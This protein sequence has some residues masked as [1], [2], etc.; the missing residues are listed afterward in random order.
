MSDPL[1]VE[2]IED[3]FIPVLVFNNRPAHAALLQEFGEPAWNNPVVRFLNADRKDLIP[4]EE[5]IWTTHGVAS[6][7]VAA[8]QSAGQAAPKYLQLLA[9]DLLSDPPA[10]R[11]I[12]QAT[13]GMHCFWEGEAKFGGLEGVLRTRAVWIEGVEGVDLVFDPRRISFRELVIEA[14]QVQCATHV[15]ARS[16]AQFQIASEFTGLQLQRLPANFVPESASA[17]DQK[18]YLRNS[19]LAAAP[20]SALQQVRINA[21]L[22]SPERNQAAVEACLSPRQIQDRAKRAAA[23]QR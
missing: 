6:R 20:L 7:M 9:E 11:R 10:D 14:Q 16:E 13:F 4:R 17:N 22:A 3:L 19:D 8:L 21:L 15:F 1:L 12:E 5:G 23:G 2:A 18:Y